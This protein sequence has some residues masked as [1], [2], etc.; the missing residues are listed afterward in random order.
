MPLSLRFALAYSIALLSHTLRFVFALSVASLPPALHLYILGRFAPSD[1]A[2][3][4]RILLA[5]LMRVSR[6]RK[7]LKRIS[8]SQTSQ[9]SLKRQSKK[10]KGLFQVL[11]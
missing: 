5:L 10:K 9:N 1:L 8:V 3:W 6:L 11:S 4:A 2:F 7:F